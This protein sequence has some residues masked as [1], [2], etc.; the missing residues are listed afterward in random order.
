MVAVLT[1][2]FDQEAANTG[3]NPQSQWNSGVYVCIFFDAPT[4]QS[5]NRQDPIRTLKPAGEG[6]G[7]GVT[8]VGLLH[9][10]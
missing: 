10:S 3:L 6:R 8:S 1:D 2:N 7:R 4:D 9:S 5:D